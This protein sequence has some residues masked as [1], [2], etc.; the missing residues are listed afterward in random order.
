MTFSTETG[1]PSGE[2]LDTIIQDSVQGLGYFHVSIL[3]LMETDLVLQT[4]MIFLALLTSLLQH[5][6]QRMNYNR[7]LA[8]IEAITRDARTAAWGNKLVPGEGKKK[9]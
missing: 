6:V 9:V 1:F 7:D 5:M 3:T 2:A 8:R 4:V